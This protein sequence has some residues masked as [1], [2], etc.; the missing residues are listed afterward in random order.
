MSQIDD[1]SLVLP[2]LTEYLE[3]VF[4]L[5]GGPIIFMDNLDAICYRVEKGDLHRRQ[6]KIAARILMRKITEFA[7]LYNKL[8]VL[9]AK[10]EANIDEELTHY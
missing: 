3:L 8:C 6:E 1:Q 7:R 2:S 10:N 5:F 9:T 4:Q